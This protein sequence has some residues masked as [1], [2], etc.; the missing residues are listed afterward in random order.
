MAQIAVGKT[1]IDLGNQQE[2]KDLREVERSAWVISFI[3]LGFIAVLALGSSFDETTF[4]GGLKVFLKAL[5]IGIAAAAASAAVGSM[6][7]FLFGIPRLLQKTPEAP[8]PGAEGAT[9]K[10]NQFFITNTSLEE[11]SD[12]LTKII[13]GLGLV[14]FETIVHYIY[15]CSLFA[16]SYIK[17]VDV[18]LSSANNADIIVKGGISVAFFFAIIIVCLLGACLFIY[19]E[20]RTRLT[21]I[22]REMEADNVN[23]GGEKAYENSLNTPLAQ[24]TPSTLTESQEPKQLSPP[25]ATDAQVV[26]VPWEQLNTATQIGGWAAAQARA[27]NPQP[28]EDALR[29]ALKREPENLNLLQR[30]AELRRFRSNAQGFVETCLE[31]IQK[32]VDR[33]PNTRALLEDALAQALYLPPPDGFSKAITIS[34]F[35]IGD[36]DSKRPLT[37]IRRACAFGQKYLAVKNTDPAAADD[38]R[39][40][41]LKAVMSAVEL[42]PEEDNPNRNILRQLLD[43]KKYGGNPRDDDLEV[44]K[45]DPDFVKIIVGTAS[46]LQK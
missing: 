28:A 41:A 11:I 39:T 8:K 46:E 22:F 13:I 45:E 16:A 10:T 42:A 27:G 4:W 24:I 9:S 31:L 35:L 40:Q 33:T 15:V 23:G 44:F 3:V 25:T 18:S 30:L 37:F 12:W 7:G 32:S 1:F 20:T 19:L 17:S 34:D 36:P 14:Q 6:L 2:S 38:A 43:P 21:R 26:N 29:D 5:S